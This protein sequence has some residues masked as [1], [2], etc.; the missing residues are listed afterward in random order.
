MTLLKCF[1]VS[2][3]ARFKTM[4]SKRCPFIQSF[5]GRCAFLRPSVYSSLHL[6]GCLFDHSYVE[7]IFPSFIQT[8]I[9][10]IA[11]SFGC[12]SVGGLQRPSICLSVGRVCPFFIRSFVLNMF[13]VFVFVFFSLLVVILFLLFVC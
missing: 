2:I 11:R 3:T 4:Q 12:S 5:V 13:C 10:C 7:S 8:V 1:Y 6:S 9:C